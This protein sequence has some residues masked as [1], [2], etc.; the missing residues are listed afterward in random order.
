MFHTLQF[1][2]LA[3]TKTLTAA[4]V[5]ES[6]A[7]AQVK[8]LLDALRQIERDDV[9]PKGDIAD[10]KIEIKSVEANILRWVIGMLLAQTGLIAALVKL[11]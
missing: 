4:G 2:T 11:L 9:A 5:P 7:E 8:A 6:Q 3:F 10:L 1:D